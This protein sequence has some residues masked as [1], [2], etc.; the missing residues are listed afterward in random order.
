MPM[1]PCI[2][3]NDRWHER[4]ISYNT[5][6]I[7]FSGLANEICLSCAS[8]LNSD[9]GFLNLALKRVVES[10]DD[11]PRWRIE[12][13]ACMCAQ[14]DEAVA[15]VPVDGTANADRRARLLNRHRFDRLDTLLGVDEPLADQRRFEHNTV[16]VLELRRIVLDELRYVWDAV[17]EP[18][19]GAERAHYQHLFCSFAHTVG[20]LAR[21]GPEQR[22]LVEALCGDRAD[23]ERRFQYDWPEDVDLLDGRHWLLA[24]AAVRTL[25]A[26]RLG[27]TLRDNLRYEYATKVDT[28]WVV[29]MAQMFADTHL[30]LS[31]VCDLFARYD[32]AWLELPLM[33]NMMASQGKRQAPA[34]INEVVQ[35][36]PLQMGYPHPLRCVYAGELIDATGAVASANLWTDVQQKTASQVASFVHVFLCK[37]GNHRC[38]LREFDVMLCREIGNFPIMIK[39]VMNLLETFQMGNYPGARHRPLWRFRKLVRRTHHYDRFSIEQWCAS[40][41]K[42]A[43]VACP[44]CDGRVPLSRDQKHAEHMCDMCSFVRSVKL[45]VF[46]AV[47]EFFVYQIR[48]QRSVEALLEAESGWIEHCDLVTL[49]CD[50]ARRLMNKPCASRNVKFYDVRRSTAEMLLHLELLHD[51]VPEDHEI[52][53]ERGFMDLDTY[54]ASVSTGDPPR[55]ASYDTDGKLLIFET[56]LELIE[57]PPAVRRMVQFSSRHETLDTWSDNAD[58]YGNVYGDPGSTR[59]FEN[60]HSNGV[61]FMV[62]R[63]H[64]VYGESGHFRGSG[65]CRSFQR[66]PAKTEA[67][68]KSRREVPTFRKIKASEFV[69]AAPDDRNWAAVRQIACAEAGVGQDDSGLECVRTRLALNTDAKFELFLELYGFWLGDGTM[70]V[71]PEAGVLKPYYVEFAQRKSGDVEWL[72]ATVRSLGVSHNEADLVSRRMRGLSIKDPAWVQFW[73]DEYGHK[74]AQPHRDGRLNEATEPKPLEKTEGGAV[75]K[76]AKWLANWVWGLSTDHLRLVLRGIWRSDGAWSS[77]V[78]IIWTSSI[79][80]RD[81]LVRLM[82]MAGY[83]ARFGCHYKKGTN[84]GIGAQDKPIIATADNWWIRW[85]A[86]TSAGGKKAAWPTLDKARGEI[87]EIEYTGRVWCFRMPSGF[88]WTRRAHKNAAGIVTKASRPVLTGNCNKPANKRLFKSF[89]LYDLFLAKM[90]RIA[91][92]SCELKQWTGCQR[93]GDFLLAPLHR[94]ELL[95]HIDEH[96]KLASLLQCD[97]PLE[98]LDNA[99]WCE[100]YKLAQ[101]DALAQF[102]AQSGDAII[103]SLAMV[104]LS[105]EAMELMLELHFNSDERDMPNNA[106]EKVLRRLFKQYPVDFHI[107]HYFFNSMSLYDQVRVRPL[108]ADTAVAQGRALRQRY[109]ISPHEPIPD[110]TDD[111]YFCRHCRIL[112]AFVVQPPANATLRQRRAVHEAATERGGD[113]LSLVKTPCARGVPLAFFDTER[114]VLMCSRDTDSSNTKKF[115][116][117]GQ[118]DEPMWL[119]DRK[120]ASSIRAA[121]EAARPCRNEPLE[122]VAMLGRLLELGGN[123]YTMCVVCASPCLFSDANM[124]DAGPTCGRHFR[125]RPTGLYQHLQQFVTPLTQQVRCFAPRMLHPVPEAIFMASKTIKYGSPDGEKLGVVASPIIDGDMFVMVQKEVYRDANGSGAV[126]KNVRVEPKDTFFKQR[127]RDAEDESERRTADAARELVRAN[128]ELFERTGVLVGRML[129]VC[130]CCG[131]RCEANEEFKRLTVNN[132]DGALV[133]FLW[134]KPIECRG[135]VDIWL[136]TND[137]NRS[138]KL[139]RQHPVPLCSQLYFSLTQ[140][141]E[142]SLQRVMKRKFR[143]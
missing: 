31:L 97:L 141:R 66:K 125:L 113:M 8:P 108:D 54:K 65:D 30:D 105:P 128:T 38:M 96:P 142:E 71:V 139:L 137:F 46:L 114:G 123:L 14:C 13:L 45:E 112:Y 132:C 4:G 53:T 89:A 47:K 83:T 10:A 12:T 92:D 81:E 91:G 34:L 49:A 23:V 136:C 109:H 120:R 67:G 5:T 131:S 118:M 24:A 75:L 111:V 61:S 11:A 85:S 41:N 58:D 42:G 87:T 59:S 88:I 126:M 48:C 124:T 39:F 134:R 119:A 99:R 102:C 29:L 32:D 18:L 51:C 50:D 116:K 122:K 19:I 76:S 74:Y 80:F 133:D 15:S 27:E 9:C 43:A 64:D 37:A 129:I 138:L 28:Q 1:L 140:Q 117:T 55:V 44:K 56:P 6:R 104:G 17:N 7:P 35:F 94:A 2:A 110:G 121:R 33:A 135:L 57:K 25:A 62:T 69:D 79:R 78:Q 130:A 60:T 72:R 21:N 3:A 90:N 73:N 16:P 77:K 70:K 95:V 100:R 22:A 103:S 106:T 143:K 36:S 52:L 107:V 82:L 68:K 20:W 26:L 127:Q 93:P 101:I 84:R 86:A 115:S 40:C 98:H 63:T